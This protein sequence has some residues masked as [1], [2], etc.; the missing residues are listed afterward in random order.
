MGLGTEISRG[1]RDIT[2]ASRIFLV[3]A[4]LSLAATGALLAYNQGAFTPT[5]R[6]YFYSGTA[7]GMNKG[8]AVK[9][10]GFNVGSVENISI[11]PD[12]RVK[13][14]LKIVEKYAPMI[15]SNAVVRL[16]REAVIGGNVL[17]VRPGTANVGPVADR[18]I[19]RYERD[20]GIEGA[21]TKLLTQVAPIVDDVRQITAY[22]SDP[23]GDFRQAMRNINLTAT[24]LNAASAGLSRLTN[25]AVARLESGAQRASTVADGAEALV[26]DARATLA[27]LGDTL[28]KVDSTLPSIASKMEQGVENFRLTSEAIRGMVSGDLSGL[29]SETGS[30]V[31]DTGDVVRGLRR[32]WPLRDVVQQPR[33]VLLR[34]DSAGGVTAVPDDSGRGR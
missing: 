23:Q 10:V 14:E 31:S 4:L 22:L 2:L 20:P 26:K 11:E 8:M 27:V 15:Y 21:V 34:L 12:L 30:V 18:S 13:V 24:Q 16:T 28:K 1:A 9:L 33:E 32:T 17:D 19:L 29:V 3:V 6:L 7:D 5:V 25:A